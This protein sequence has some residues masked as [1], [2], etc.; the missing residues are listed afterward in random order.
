VPTHA[1]LEKRRR[2]RLSDIPERWATRPIPVGAADPRDTRGLLAPAR[3]HHAVEDMLGFCALAFRGMGMPEVDAN[4]R[5]VL[6]AVTAL[7]P[8]FRKARMPFLSEDVRVSQ[9]QRRVDRSASHARRR[10]LQQ[11][12]DVDPRPWKAD[13]VVH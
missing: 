5:L 2:Q 12:P 7:E 11:N 9:S 1:V 13:Q 8:V 3:P 10:P 4:D 6:L